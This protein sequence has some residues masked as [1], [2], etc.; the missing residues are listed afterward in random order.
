M[1]DL[2]H[3]TA[4]AFLPLLDLTNL[5][6]GT[7]QFSPAAAS[8]FALIHDHCTVWPLLVSGAASATALSSI[9]LQKGEQV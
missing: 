9:L 5:R 6:S 1:L 4:A 2:T 3:T 8:C 7:S